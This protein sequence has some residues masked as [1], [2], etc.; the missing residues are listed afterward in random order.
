MKAGFS[1]SIK[2]RIY[3]SFSLLVFLF[4]INGIITILTI[5]SNKKLTEHL[6]KGVEPSLQ[7]I[8]D[9]E[10]MLVE[11]RMYT[12]NWVFLRSNTEDKRQLEKI[13]QSGYNTIKL[14]LNG[15]ATH[16]VNKNWVDSLNK[17]F[18]GFEELLAVEKNIMSSLHEFKDYDDPVIKL[19]AE[20]KV[21][22]EVLPRSTALMNALNTIQQFGASI[23]NSE[24][25]LLEKTSLKLRFFIFILVLTIICAGMLLSIYLTRVIVGPINKI[26]LIVNDLGKGIIRAIDPHTKK[27]EIGEMVWSIN[28][29][30]EKLSITT[31]FA[32]EIGNRNFDSWYEPLSGEDTLGRALITMRDNLKSSE[33][34]LAVNTEELERKNKELEQFAYVASHDLQEPLR[35]TS[36]FVEL[37]Q[38]QYK[39]KL[40]DKADKYLNFITQSSERM[41]VLIK[42]LLDYSRIGHKRELQRVD[43]NRIL[44]DVL[45][46]LDA[47]ILETGAEIMADPLPVISGYPTEVK[48]LFQN[49]VANAIKFR[50]K[51]TIPKI[52]IFVQNMQ[53]CWEFAFR[54]NG[55]G[56]EREHRERIFIIFQRL[57]TRTLYKGS[58][59]GLSHCKK[60]V[61]LHNGKIWVESTPGHGSTFYFTIHK[62]HNGDRKIALPEFFETTLKIPGKG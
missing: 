45:A 50:Q 1:I 44:L 43:C 8:G 39:G 58:G 57:H 6:S 40:D 60:I 12:T 14:R 18:T 37:L 34:S 32:N 52:E 49:L 30:S 22:E 51:D 53:D 48:Q 31:A 59:I 16:W 36:S 9:F 54:D 3:W 17:V 56:I 4:V 11:S 26:R 15:Y 7:A 20:R 29:L 33:A 5:N 55:I 41:E 21:E 47:A 62:N 46:D 38:Q 35:T 28:N 2:K 13:H 10:D 19:E 42:D 24:N 25:D 27:D 61:E 23:R